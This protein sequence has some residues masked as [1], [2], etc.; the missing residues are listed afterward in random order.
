[1]RDLRSILWLRWRQFQDGAVYWLR[2]LGYQPNEQSFSQRMY[3]LYLVGIGLLWVGTMWSWGY[4]QANAIGVALTPPALSDLLT[5]LPIAVLIGQVFVL[6]TA[7]R[8][9]PLKLSFADMAY[10][11]GSPVSPLAPIFVG[12]I[13]QLLPRLLLIGMGAALLAVMLIRPF[14]S[15]LGGTAAV[16]AVLEVIPLVIVTW[17][18]A[19][20]L[21]IL[22]LVYPRI[23]R[24]RWFWL[25]PL[26]LLVLAY[27]APDVVLWPGRAWVL[28]VYG[29]LPGWVL[30]F[31]L[32]VTV[33]IV[34]VL[35]RISDRAN[36]VQAADESIL[37]A[38]IQALGLLAW[39]QPDLQFRIR[40]QATQ[41]S[42]KPWLRL[43]RAQGLWMLI[44]RAGV[45]YVRHPLMLILTFAWGAVMSY[46]AVTTVINRPPPQLWIAWL[47]AAAFVPPQGLFY[48]FQRDVDERFLRQFLPVDGL[49]LFAADVVVP[50]LFLIAGAMF[51]L[52]LPGFSPLVIAFGALMIPV[53]AVLL[54]LCGAVA[55]TNKR[56]LQVR[57][58][59]IGLSFGAV[60]L[61][62]VGLESP[63]AAFGVAIFAIL[64]LTGLVA[65][66]A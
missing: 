62:G 50:L 65:S 30:P 10:I 42:R 31:V 48:V 18:L 60:I 52:L 22:R 41:A 35:L 64:V 45:S 8:S 46:L 3:V 7:L 25:L 13:R 58:L 59:A 55:L 5:A 36:M 15:N 34:A 56:V 66:N 11:A 17:A 33:F 40:M 43:P 27:I 53:L 24:W 44:T 49:Q 38:R 32:L 47:L 20:L 6:V 26:L 14:G 16:R 19:W 51:G 37:Y 63:L 12:F 54:A 4:D 28:S 21:G 23:G 1:M 9:T 2:V 39:R 61:V 29:R 57:L